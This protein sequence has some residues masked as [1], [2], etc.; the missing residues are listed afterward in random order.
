MTQI[1]KKRSFGVLN[2]ISSFY[3]N[4]PIG[5]LGDTAI[6]FI[7]W[8][9]HLGANIWQILPLCP[10]G[11]YNSPY[12]SPASFA[13]NPL[14]IDLK[15]LVNEGFL[16]FSEINIF[17]RYDK[18]DYEFSKSF[19]LPLLSKAAQN[20]LCSR[21]SWLS[22]FEKYCL[23]HEWLTDSCLF[24]ALKSKFQGLKW[25]NW[26]LKIRKRDESILNDLKTELKREID[27]Y[28]AIFFFFDKEWQFIKDY[29][30]KLG[31]TIIG[32][33]PIYVDEDSSEVW[34]NQEIFKLDDEC[35]MIAK[36]GVPPDSFSPI[37]QLWGNP[38][39]RWDVMKKD[40][41]SWWK[42]RLLRL[43]ELTDIV[44]I[45]HFRG[46]SAYWEIR[47]DALD[48]RAGKWV[49]GPGQSFFDEI[50][51][52]I[53]NMPIVA[54]DLGTID[55][56]VEELRDNNNLY[57]MR[58][59]Q[60]GFDDDDPKNIHLPRNYIKRS[61]AYTG[62][63]DVPPS[64]GWWRTLD[65]TQLKRV[66]KYFSFSKSL[67]ESKIVWRFIESVLMSDAEVAIIPIQDI[68]EL[69][70]EARMNDPSKNDGNWQ[71]RM[72]ENH[73]DLKAAERLK[74]LAEKANRL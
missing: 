58:V 21:H 39:Y 67:K 42:K 52:V 35:R 20:F 45:D 23:A 18:V 34:C 66:K 73:I 48:A 37:G 24:F 53:P 13:G 26:P 68:F 28:K 62:N 51:K 30:H 64:L 15:I 4:E 11:K 74:M 6:K 70:M 72:S 63:H 59:L 41:F 19:K 44:R 36:S 38:I 16:D 8:L 27:I 3:G 33:L 12:F 43:L 2:H 54:E 65:K 69:G 9:N 49:E 71:W 22:E 57:G 25:W 56:A 1:F 40:K 50:K 17:N 46:L 10:N 60:F 29:A 31:I 55:K 5:T 32:D 61:L 7:D 47:A 14:L